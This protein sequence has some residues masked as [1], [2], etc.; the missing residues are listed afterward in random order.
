MN[1]SERSLKVLALVITVALS[2]LMV[3]CKTTQIKIGSSDYPEASATARIVGSGPGSAN[4]L[5][6][7]SNLAADVMPEYELSDMATAASALGTGKMFHDASGAV[8]I[9]ID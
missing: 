8:F 1:N 2:V 6:D 9:T 5:A 4:L 3:G 7:L